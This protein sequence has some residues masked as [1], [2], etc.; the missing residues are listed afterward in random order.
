MR[1]TIDL[2]ALDRYWQA[3]NSFGK[4]IVRAPAR[5]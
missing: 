2:A 1:L 4:S 3:A 5:V